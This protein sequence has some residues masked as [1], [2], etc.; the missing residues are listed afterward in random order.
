MNPNEVVVHVVDRDGRDV[1]LDLL[2]ERI[3]ESREPANLHPHREVLAF[4]IAGADMLGIGIADQRFLLA[5]NAFRRAVLP[6]AGSTLIDRSTI[7][8]NQGRIVHVIAESSRNRME[9]DPQAVRGQLN[10][11]RQTALK[12]LNEDLGRVP[13]AV[14]DHPGADEFRIGVHRNPGPDIASVGIGGGQPRCDVLL[15]GRDEAP[16]LVALNPFARKIN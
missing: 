13:V 12:I 6:C 11:I 3:G 1:V 7:P 15:F 5:A 9:V 2:R 16:N 4:D 10:P 8:L 14:P